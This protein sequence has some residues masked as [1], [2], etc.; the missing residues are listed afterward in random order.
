MTHNL[1]KE[2]QYI[3]NVMRATTALSSILLM[4]LGKI[5]IDYVATNTIDN[6]NAEAQKSFTETS[7]YALGVSVLLASAGI[8]KATH[9]Y[10]KRDL[11]TVE[12]DIKN[13]N[14]EN[15]KTFALE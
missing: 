8:F 5:F 4:S 11:L 15:L 10:V 1:N 2:K 13:Q 7:S 3:Y 12:N 9:Q 6:N 14:T